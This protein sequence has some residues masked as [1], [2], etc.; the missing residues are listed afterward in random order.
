MPA[1]IFV[2]LVSRR[3]INSIDLIDLDYEAQ[4]FG[5]LVTHPMQINFFFNA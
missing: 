5:D 4:V 1:Y 2:A 3:S